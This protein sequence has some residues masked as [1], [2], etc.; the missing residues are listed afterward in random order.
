MG[1]AN[2]PA[3]LA[4]GD[5]ALEPVAGMTLWIDGVDL[6]GSDN[7]TLTDGQ[8]LNSVVNKGTVGGT[9]SNGA[10]SVRPTFVEADSAIAF[11]KNSNSNNVLRQTTAL[12]NFIGAKDWHVFA[13]VA[14][15]NFASAAAYNGPR[16]I[17]DTYPWWSFTCAGGGSPVINGTAMKTLPTWKTV[18]KATTSGVLQLTEWSADGGSPANIE[19][20]VDDSGAPGTGTNNGVNATGLAN[21]V[22]IGS[23]TNPGGGAAYTYEGQ[24]REILVYPSKLSTEDRDAN[25]AYLQAKWGL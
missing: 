25:I 13:V 15:T 14:P 16:I 10:T 1:H 24:I 4:G 7:S 9:F 18:S 19:V 23:A 3:V 20:D 2:T 22:Y 5:G 8:Y 6:D 21:N 12:S 17:G 11:I